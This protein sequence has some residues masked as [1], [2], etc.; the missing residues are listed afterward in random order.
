[1]GNLCPCFTKSESELPPAF[2]PV[3]GLSANFKGSQITVDGMTVSGTGSI[4]GDSPLLQDKAY[5]EMTLV[6]AGVFA[7]GVATRDTP[8][9]GV[10]SQEKV[11]VCARD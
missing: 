2:D 6:K 4:F 1:M 11:R 7:V 9:E 3:I 8:L 10:L 5:F